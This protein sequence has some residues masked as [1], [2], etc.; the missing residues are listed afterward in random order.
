MRKPVI[1]AILTALGA[2]F[3]LAHSG[4]TG[5]V[6]E[7]MDHMGHIG[8]A[9]KAIGQMIHGKAEYDPEKVRLAARAIAKSGGKA[10]TAMFPENSIKGP[11]E[12]RPEIWTN[13]D[14]FVAMAL[15]LKTT[16]QALADGADNPMDGEEA[17]P[18]KLFA[19]MAGTCKAC[20]KE[21]RI[22]K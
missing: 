11:S 19:A 17:A 4:A 3:A 16:A 12:A 8:K 22:K 15:S 21:F 1:A 13:W 18:D 6:K 2:G 10:M 9:T 7:R 20:H 14:R 5:I